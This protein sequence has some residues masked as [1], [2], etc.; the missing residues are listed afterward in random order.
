MSVRKVF[1]WLHLT[2]GVI[3]GVIV[4]LMSVTGVLLM[5]QRQMLAWS[6]SKFRSEPP[7]GAQRLS[8]KALV[9]KVQESEGSAPAAV[10][11]RS[12]PAEP[13]SVAFG[14][15]I[16]YV[17]PYTG[18]VLGEGSKELRAF[19]QS[20]T[21]WHRWLGVEGPGRTAA[22][23]ITGA[24]NLA[25]LFLVVS[26]FYLWWPRKWTVRNLRSVTLFRGG[27]PAKARDFNWHNVIGFWSAVPLFFVV[28]SGVVISYPWASDMVYRM[29]G[30]EPPARLGPGGP[31][32]PGGPGPEARPN[33]AGRRAGGD[34][35]DRERAG[36]DRRGLREDRGP[37]EEGRDEA[38][39]LEGVDSLLA[40]AEQ[41]VPD[42]YSISLR[43][44]HSPR[45]PVVFS[46]D[47]TDGG[48]PQT[49]SQLTLHRATGEEISWEPFSRQST[50][51]QMRMLLRFA[52]TGEVAGLP[53]QTIAGL[54]SAGAVVMVWTGLALS[55]RRFRAWRSRRQVAE[56][57]TVMGD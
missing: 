28:Y 49:R 7:P 10:T 14:R 25:F 38:V 11:F 4:L 54:V 1:F 33:K 37:R 16:V 21:S 3:A 12:D 19:F 40:K 15:R 52:H 26:G 29:A 56:P 17:N 47:T 5:Y 34:R 44:P 22:R 43:L 2:A 55:W 35:G 24:C 32:R 57:E 31:G 13:A 42:W 8:V 27:L 51:R 50:G 48:R 39:S 30:E 53:G 36:S 23:A 18:A 41:I 9:A 46:I 45:A 20:V 6:D